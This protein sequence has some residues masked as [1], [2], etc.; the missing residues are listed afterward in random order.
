MLNSLKGF[1]SVL[2]NM[3]YWVEMDLFH[4]AQNHKNLLPQ[5]QGAWRKKVFGVTERGIEEAA[6]IWMGELFYPVYVIIRANKW[7][8]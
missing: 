3:T 1:L 7:R 8:R 5:E 4:A 2:G 6:A